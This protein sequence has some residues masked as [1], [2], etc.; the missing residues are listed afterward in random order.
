MMAIYES[1]LYTSHC[2]SQSNRLKDILFISRTFR[3]TKYLV[4]LGTGKADRGR[5]G[6]ISDTGAQAVEH[7]S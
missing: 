1:S 4:L 6:R 7:S 5:A 2:S 3:T